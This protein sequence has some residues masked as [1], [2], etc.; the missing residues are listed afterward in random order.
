MPR[1]QR[2]DSRYRPWRSLTYVDTAGAT[3]VVD[4]VVNEGEDKRPECGA[5]TTL[6][7]ICLA[8]SLIRRACL[9]LLSNFCR[10]RAKIGMSIC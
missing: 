1:I 6:L 7:S 8:R 5:G 10:S 4:V 9:L 2:R 3:E